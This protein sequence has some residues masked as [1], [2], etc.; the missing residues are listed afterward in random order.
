LP[1]AFPVRHPSGQ[2][3]F[4]GDIQ[5]RM[6]CSTKVPVFTFFSRAIL[7]YTPC[8]SI[9]IDSYPLKALN[10]K[11]YGFKTITFLFYRNVFPCF[12]FSGTPV[13]HLNTFKIRCKIPL[14]GGR[15]RIPSKLRRDFADTQ[16]AD[17]VRILLKE[18]KKAGDNYFSNTT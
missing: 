10:K 7:R 2:A 1:A 4:Q 16:P 15:I 5:H 11:G 9:C 17:L 6:T 13:E 3:L 14:C 8:I 12:K 18:Q